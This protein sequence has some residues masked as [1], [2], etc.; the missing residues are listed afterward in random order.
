MPCEAAAAAAAPAT[1]ADDAAA[2][3]PATATA[4]ATDARLRATTR[5][6][7]GFTWQQLLRCVPGWDMV[8]GMCEEMSWGRLVQCLSSATVP[9]AVPAA[10]LEW[11][12]DVELLMPS[13]TAGNVQGRK[14][15]TRCAG[16]KPG[17]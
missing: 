17:T 8:Y 15:H 5:A 1:T 7:V 13:V 3:V 16:S 4:T 11:Y 9:H 14:E 10:L 12:H 6:A 2:A